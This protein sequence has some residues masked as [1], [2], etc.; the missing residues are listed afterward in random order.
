M[1]LSSSPFYDIQKKVLPEFANISI[2]PDKTPQQRQLYKN[3]KTEMQT[4]IEIDK[5]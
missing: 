4:K 1:D 2:M 3:L 5:D